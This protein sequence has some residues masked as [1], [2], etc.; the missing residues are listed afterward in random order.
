[1]AVQIELLRIDFDAEY[2]GEAGATLRYRVHAHDAKA[3]F[4]PIILDV[5]VPHIGTINDA[6]DRGFRAIHRMAQALEE[7][8]RPIPNQQAGGTT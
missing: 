8:L 2:A 3:D 5:T 1:M 6:V 7:K 4:A